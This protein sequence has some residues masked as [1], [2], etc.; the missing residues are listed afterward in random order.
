MYVLDFVT[1]YLGLLRGKDPG[2]DSLIAK[3]KTILKAQ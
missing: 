3:L 2:D 1:I